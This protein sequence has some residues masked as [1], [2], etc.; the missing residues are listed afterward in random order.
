[1]S[2]YLS[3]PLEGEGDCF[4]LFCFCVK[5]EKLHVCIW[6]HYLLKYWSRHTVEA[7]S[8]HVHFHSSS[9]KRPYLT[10]RCLN[11]LICC[12]FGFSDAAVM[13]D[14]SERLQ[15]CDVQLLLP[16]MKSRRRRMSAVQQLN[17]ASINS[18]LLPV[19][20]PH[21]STDQTINILKVHFILKK[22]CIY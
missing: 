18:S 7:D 2:W 10:R 6:H 11:V 1:M 3:P 21:V 17:P 4:F 15:E 5:L 20:S 14:L 22:S 16:H 19:C 9:V 12:C 8:V 13:E